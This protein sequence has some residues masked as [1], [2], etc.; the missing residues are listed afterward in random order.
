M[1][2]IPAKEALYRRIETEMNQIWNK[3]SADFKS[4]SSKDILAMVAFR[5]AQVYYDMLENLDSQQE[6]LSQAE[7]ALDKI[8]L[9]VK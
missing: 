1:K 9:D 4:K 7:A 5:Y 3:W 8:L 2:I 6:A